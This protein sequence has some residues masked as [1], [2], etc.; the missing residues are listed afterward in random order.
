MPIYIDKDDDITP[1][2]VGI[3]LSNGTKYEF[4]YETLKNR[5]CF[6]DEDSI[7]T[8]LE[9]TVIPVAPSSNAYLTFSSDA[10]FTLGCVD[11]GD[12]R[13]P[14]WDGILEYS[15]DAETWTQ[16]NGSAA[17]SS[18]ADNEIHLRGTRNTSFA[19]LDEAEGYS[20]WF[21]NFDI[22][23]TSGVACSGNIET[24][25]DYATVERGEHP[26][27]GKCCFDD[28]FNG[29]TSLI[30]APE[31]PATTLSIGCYGSMFMNC[32]SLTTAPQLPATTLAEGCYSYMFFGCT[33]LTTA[34]QL[35][36]TTLADYCYEYMFGGCTSIKVSETQTSEYTTPYRIPS[37]GTGVD[38]QNALN[39]M[40]SDTGGI[41]TGTPTINTTYY[42]AVN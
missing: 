20:P 34:L 30:T 5:P 6:N 9:E 3:K 35:P 2:I 31:L 32:T 41:F 33:S 23:G 16:W 39:D 15:T 22:Q 8:Y 17:I 21:T 26:E 25:L 37:E 18:G 4:N 1:Y 42:L 28:L 27:M 12:W 13:R 7:E 38:A 29:C 19:P 14:A 11:D 36:A 40:F 24:L 10:P